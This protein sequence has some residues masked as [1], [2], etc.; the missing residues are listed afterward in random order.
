MTAPRRLRMLDERRAALETCGYCPKLCRS[1]CPV[2]DAEASESLIPWGK[3]TLTWYVARGDLAPDRDL[4]RLPWACTGCVGCRELCEHQ[5]P[6]VPTL[7]AARA[8]YHADGLAP[9]GSEAALKRFVGKRE[10]L[11]RRARALAGGAHDAVVA[12]LVGCGY[13]GT[14]GSEAQD[15]VDAARGLCGPV[16]VLEGCCGLPLKEGGDAMAAHELCTRLLTE[17]KG[18]RL[19]VADAGCAAELREAG[20]QTLVEVAGNR[21]SKLKRVPELPAALRWHDPCRLA[22]G[23]GVTAEPRRVLERALGVPVQEFE[24]AGSNTRCSGGGALLPF[25]MPKTARRIA[26]DRIAEHERL[27]GGTLVTACATS[28]GW[29]RAQGANVLDLATIIARSLTGD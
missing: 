7:T 10:R 15:V 19:V 22:R 6:V 3:M 4:A 28:L 16:H 12:V 20:A 2:S 8:V 24:R 18:R 17:V 25:V 5:N 21:V 1:T 14:R 23:L 27:G 9:S 11:R 26:Q 13:L 29:F